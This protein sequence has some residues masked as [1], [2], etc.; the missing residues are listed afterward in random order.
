MQGES[1]EHE[2]SVAVQFGDEAPELLRRRVFRG[3]HP[4]IQQGV[5]AHLDQIAVQLGREI[6]PPSESDIMVVAIH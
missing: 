2:V 6:R 4:Q 1:L 5:D 3:R